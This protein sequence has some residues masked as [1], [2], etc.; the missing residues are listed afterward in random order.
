VKRICVSLFVMLTGTTAA[1]AQSKFSFV[2]MS[3]IHY[4]QKFNAPKGFQM[5]VDTLNQMN[6]DLVM[7]GGDIIYDALRVTEKELMGNTNAYLKA[8]SQIKAPLHYAVGN[9]EVFELYQK[10][11]DTSGALFGKRYYEKYFGKRYYSFN[12]KGWHFMVLD[13]IYITPDR[14]YI[15]K[16]DSVQLSWIK[17]DLKTVSEQT[18]IVMMMHVPLISTL[19]QW[20]GGG[21]NA[22]DDK[23]A[24]VDSHR[25]L[26]LFES[27]NLRLVLQ[28]HLHYFE[29]L[30]I[31]NKTMV[32]T[33]PSVSGK[34]WRGKQ[35]EVEEGFIRINVDGDK[36][37]Y[38]YVD[39]GWEPKNK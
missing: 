12:H 26:R 37:E 17:E 31:L 32:I 10:N 7:V 9:H 38:E 5:L 20:Y 39:F 1:L 35:H 33:A 18:P 29:A 14:K 34:W 3:D 4:T 21:T 15:G 36:L 23:V 16:I 25:L 22:N 28:G 24:A 30:N 6:P 27:K 2:F 13:N 11:A 8:A 19:S